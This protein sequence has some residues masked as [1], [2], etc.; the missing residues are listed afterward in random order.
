P[1]IKDHIVLLLEDSSQDDSAE[2]IIVAR[3]SGLEWRLENR[4]RANKQKML[5]RTGVQSAG[6]I[7]SIRTEL[8]NALRTHK[9]SAGSS[10]YSLNVTCLDHS[11]AWTSSISGDDPLL[12]DHVLPR[13][14]PFEVI[15]AEA[16]GI[17]KKYW[18]RDVGPIDKT[19]R[20]ELRPVEKTDP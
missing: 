11:G 1:Q 17:P 2:L 5:L 3:S 6:R 15:W 16:T 18:Y 8:K 19:A 20:E 4:S 14:G 10:R 7:D 13:G 9:G 12:W